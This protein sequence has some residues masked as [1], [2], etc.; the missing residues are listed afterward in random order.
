MII[1]HL[2][3]MDLKIP[4]SLSRRGQLTLCVTWYGAHTMVLKA[5][6]MSQAPLGGHSHMMKLGRRWGIFMGAM[7]N[8][9]GYLL[10]SGQHNLISPL[11]PLTLHCSSLTEQMF[12]PSVPPE[13][14]AHHPD[15]DCQS[16]KPGATTSASE[17]WTGAHPAHSSLR[18]PQ[19]CLVRA[20]VGPALLRVLHTWLWHNPARGFGAL[21]LGA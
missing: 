12:P 8:L 3:W 13:I 5:C 16:S 11:P 20:H 6:L 4:W 18:L 10:H 9:P 1:F 17:G 14:N 19:R 15:R 2:T 21:H 7:S